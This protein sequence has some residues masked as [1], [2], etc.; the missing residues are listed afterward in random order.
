MFY[1]E[2]YF[3][4]CCIESSINADNWYDTEDEAFNEAYDAVL[5]WLVE[6]GYEKYESTDFTVDV[7]E[8]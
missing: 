2:I 5:E 6:D 3:E 8:K 1:Y 7:I 4:G